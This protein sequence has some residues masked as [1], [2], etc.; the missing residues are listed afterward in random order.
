[1]AIT[2]AAR[3]RNARRVVRRF[4][5]MTLT[6][7]RQ[8]SGNTSRFT[9]N[10]PEFADF[11]PLGP[12]E[13]FALVVPHPDHELPVL[14]LDAH[15]DPRAVLLTIPAGR[16]PAIRWYTV[17]AHRPATKEIDVDIVL[18]GDA[19]P[20]SSWANRARPGDRVGFREATA[21]YLSPGS[22][23]Q[24][25]VADETAL[26]ALAA[27]LA[28][29][30]ADLDATVLA[31]VPY[32]EDQP[33]IPTS[34]PIRWHHRG[35]AVPGSAV[36]PALA[37]L[38]SHG[39]PELGYA[40]LCGEAAIATGARRMLVNDTGTDPDRIMFSGYWRVGQARE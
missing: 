22:G 27:I 36:L 11:D 23:H 34:V 28:A 7:R 16:R 6:A 5:P 19:G 24:L 4:F 13:F 10:A 20:A 26:P 17:R 31:E 37:Q 29:A 25:L 15:D 40:W 18:H 3:A 35:A 12:D 39:L 33:G 1:M 2:R 32:P 8:V 38:V 30:P 21:P 14:A 9:F